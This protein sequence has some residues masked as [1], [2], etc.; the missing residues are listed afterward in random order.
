MPDDKNFKQSFMR[1][2]P[3]GIKGIPIPTVHLGS[4]EDLRDLITDYI[5][6]NIEEDSKGTGKKKIKRQ[7]VQYP[8]IPLKINVNGED[9][10]LNF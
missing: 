5:L 8:T 10:V 7:I 2:K 3:K 6:R 4:K 9:V 1:N